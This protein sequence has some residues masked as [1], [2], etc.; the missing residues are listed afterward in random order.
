MKRLLAGLL[1]ILLVFQTA[2]TQELSVV[3]GSRDY[4]GNGVT[5]TDKGNYFDVSLDFTK[6][7]SHK[8]IG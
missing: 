5:I 2:C 7:L 8:V 6:V 3:K 4:K 1:F